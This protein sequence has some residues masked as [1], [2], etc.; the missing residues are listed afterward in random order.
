MEMCDCWR[1]IGFGYFRGKFNIK[2]KKMLN[3]IFVVG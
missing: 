2:V 1:E 3:L